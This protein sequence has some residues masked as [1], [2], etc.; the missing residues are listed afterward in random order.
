MPGISA[1]K[2][3]VPFGAGGIDWLHYWTTLLAGADHL[4]FYDFLSPDTIT[5]DG[6][7]F[8]SRWNDKLGTGNDILQA[9][10]TNQPKLESDGVLFDGVDNFMSVVFAF[11]HPNYV[12]LVLKQITYTQDDYLMD[13]TGGDNLGAL[14]QQVNTPELQLQIQP[15]VTAGNNQLAINTF[16]VVTVLVDAANSYLKINEGAETLLVTAGN[17]SMNGITF[18][19]PG[20]Y[21]GLYAN[22]KLKGAILRKAPISS[23]YND[24]K[25]YYSI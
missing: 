19:K 15:E 12:Y 1:T 2:I 9:T 10:G 18:G 14:K 25:N 21:D 17:H 16:G 4:A 11:L 8:M 23:L 3:A 13:G 22:F 5:K 24:L 6:S 20:S 7:D